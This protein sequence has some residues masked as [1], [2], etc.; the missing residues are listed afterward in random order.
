MNAEKIINIEY[1]GIKY[2]MDIEVDSKNHIFYGNGIATSNSHSTSYAIN[3]FRSAY[4][5]THDPLKFYCIYLNHAHNKPD[6]Q[7]EIRELVSDAKRNGIEVY[8]PRLDHF[9]RT[10]KMDRDLNVIYF[11]YSNVKNVGEGEQEKIEA[12]V[13]DVQS[14]LN[15]HVSELCWMEILFYFSEKVKKN[16][17]ISLVS[18]GGM[19][20]KNNKKQ[21]NEMLF[22]YKT[23]LDLTA[24]E[25]E[26]IVEQYPFKK[27]ESLEIAMRDCINNN[28]KINKNRILVVKD[29]YENL[30]TPP[31]SLKDS[32]EWI[33]DIED[34]L[35][36]CSL[37]CVKTDALIT[38]DADCT[39]RD[40]T[41]KN[42]RQGSAAVAIKINR[43]NEYAIKN[44]EKKGEIMAFITGEDF[45]G[46]CDSF[47]AFPNEYKKCK[48][49][50]FVGNTVIL[51][52][53][54][55]ERDK[56]FSFVIN[57]VKQI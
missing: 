14:Q 35:M 4:C 33:S 49:L 40:I 2:T 56:D 55:K 36:G 21:R 51:F 34:K 7:E 30:K 53:T 18:V 3:A 47:V 31:Y 29:L 13:N 41:S 48:K 26:W 22:E 8:P 32:I 17:F 45:T 12:K 23:W 52:G 50:L 38:E 16:A 46:E 15:K 19:N 28:S 6:K 42:S 9:H 10:F 27:Y 25:K 20:G 24:K 11:G 57:D 44:G 1:V 54:V 5:K 37:S 43:C 39:C